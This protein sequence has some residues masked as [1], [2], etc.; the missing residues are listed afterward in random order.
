MSVDTEEELQNPQHGDTW[1]L[2]LQAS[3]GFGLTAVWRIVYD[4]P[5][6]CLMQGGQPVICGLAVEEGSRE[7]RMIT[8]SGFFFAQ[9]FIEEDQE[10][11]LSA[12]RPE[13]DI[14]GSPFEFRATD[15]Y[16]AI[17]GIHLGSDELS[18]DVPGKHPESTEIAVIATDAL[19]CGRRFEG[20]E[21]ELV[22]TIVP[23]SGGHHHFEADDEPGTGYYL[24]KRDEDIEQ[25]VKTSGLSDENGVYST[26][27]TAGEFG[28]K[29]RITANAKRE[30]SEPN[31]VVDAEQV[32]TELTIRVP[33]LVDFTD[34]L[35]RSMDEPKQEQ[36]RGA[37]PH[38]E[39][40]FYIAYAGGCPHQ[41]PAVWVTPDLRD[42]IIGINAVYRHYFDENLSFNDG[43]LEW[44][45]K[46]DNSYIKEDEGGRD[47]RCHRSH[48][49]GIDIDVNRFDTS[50]TGLVS[51]V[52]ESGLIIPN[53]RGMELER[54]A[55]YFG[56]HRLGSTGIH[57]R[58]K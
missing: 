6:D 25:R 4:E 13:S 46:I 28:L 29:E 31:E 43:S 8:I 33:G 10:Y 55:R 57:F 18:P 45:G 50:G 22:N 3:H 15:F 40:G 26:S 53:E 54:I 35:W 1:E 36:R 58:I 21:I 49:E 38:P 44:G 2:V 52:D 34:G 14:P 56:A 19:G 11:Q 32:E 47:T 42:A 39:Y 37:G 41:P 16:P 12:E 5:T 23:D 51:G 27:Y 48:R 9:C 17:G 20:L 7:F 30:L 24:G